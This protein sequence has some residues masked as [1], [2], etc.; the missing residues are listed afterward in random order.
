[1]AFA[2]FGSVNRPGLRENLHR[3]RDRRGDKRCTGW[4][5]GSR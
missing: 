4:R 3:R 5:G 2:R 1:V